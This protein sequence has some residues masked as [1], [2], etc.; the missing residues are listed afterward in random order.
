MDKH[1]EFNDMMEYVFAEE[2]SPEFLS[3]AAAFNKH[4]MECDACREMY[5]QLFNLREA[6]EAYSLFLAKPAKTQFRVFSALSNVKK[7]ES[8]EKILELSGRFRDWISF[9]IN[10]LRDISW[11]NASGFQHPRLVTE[12]KSVTGDGAV[13]KSESVI[14]SSLLDE[15]KNRVSVGLDRTLTVYLQANSCKEGQQILLLPEDDS[16]SPELQSLEKYDGSCLYA[17]FL[18]VDPGQYS[19][20]VEGEE[21]EVV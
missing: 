8:V 7:N 1:I 21:V 6:M 2:F 15:Q 13:E 19:I 16:S 4:I 11:G 17:R 20:L 14:R 12:M 9:S 18:D 3:V 10:S 5:H